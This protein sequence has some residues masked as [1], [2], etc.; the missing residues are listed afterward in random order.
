MRK[1]VEWTLNGLSVVVGVLLLSLIA[2]HYFAPA[3]ETSP[4]GGPKPGTSLSLSNTDWAATRLTLVIAMQEGCHWCEASADFYRD[5]IRSNATN[6]VHI[7]AVLPQAISQGRTF[8]RSINVDVS[9]VRQV[10]F[11]K[12]GVQATPT[13]VLVDGGGHVKSSWVGKLSQQ[14]E[15]EVFTKL[16]EK[17]LATP[18][19]EEIE[20][21]YERSP[22]VTDPSAVT[23]AQLIQM[24][25]E[26]GIVPIIDIRPR[27]DYGEGHIVGSLNIPEDELDARVEHEVPKEA[28]VVIYCHYCLPCESLQHSRGAGTLCTLG[29][30]WLKK[31][32]FAN[33]KVLSDDLSHL[34]SAGV[35]IIGVSQEKVASGSTPIQ[36]PF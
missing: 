30:T 21:Q 35:G 16:G 36:P 9:D 11:S 8:L 26:G 12:L 28:T 10:D 27:L 24:E 25:K 6:A 4:I 31:F 22:S 33:V 32:G 19:S 20:Q 18:S 13:L 17:R 14:Q 23:G 3:G 29:K 5:L 34:Q 2:K 7:V 1:I 15:E